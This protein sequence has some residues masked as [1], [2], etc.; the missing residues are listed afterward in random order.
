MLGALLAL[1]SPARAQTFPE[2]VAGYVHDFASMLSPEL[3]GDLDRELYAFERDMTNEISV[4][5]IESL[6]GADLEDYS[7]ELANRWGIGQR[8]RDNGVMLLV[9]ERDRRLRIE[10]GLGLEEV[11]TDDVA[12]RIIEEEIVP[13]FR[14][15]EFDAGVRDGVHAIMAATEDAFAPPGTLDRIQDVL[16]G[17]MAVALVVAG[18]VLRFR[19][20]RRTWYG[21]SSGGSFGGGSFGG[22]SFGG[23]GASG[24]W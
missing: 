19:L 10:V 9:V 7:L 13:R 12:R 15:G 6:E 23:G 16:E 3:E 14:A 5:T 17:V 20:G 2:P 11:M 21:R 4:V 1:A 18:L 24:S 8:E 22:G